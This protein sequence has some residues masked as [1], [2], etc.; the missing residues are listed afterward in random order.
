MKR[1]LE[2]IGKILICLPFFGCALLFAILDYQTTIVGLDGDNWIPM[3]TTITYT[4][5]VH[6]WGSGVRGQSGLEYLLSPTYSFIAA[7]GKTYIG[8]VYDIP[9]GDKSD[10]RTGN[11]EEL[12]KHLIQNDTIYY[13]PK[14][15]RQSA[16]QQPFFNPAASIGIGLVVILFIYLAI[17]LLIEEMKSLKKHE[18]KERI[19]HTFNFS[20]GPD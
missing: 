5:R 12:K 16:V 10:R 9:F 7:D 11:E 13:N 6:V 3:P 15:P 8:H 17:R 2:T 18:N 4:Y 19:Q 20:S 1:K 14:D